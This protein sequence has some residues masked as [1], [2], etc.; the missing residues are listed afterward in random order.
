MRLW[1][2]FWS[3]GFAALLCACGATEKGMRPG[4]SEEPFAPASNAAGGT[5]GGN[6]VMDGMADTGAISSGVSS[7]PAL[8]DGRYV[9]RANELQLEVNPALGGRITRFSLGGANILTGPEV[10]ARGEGTVPNM[11][12]STFWTSP[13]STWDWP[14]ETALDSDPLASSLDGDVLSLMSQAGATTGYGVLKRFALDAT[15]ERVLLEYV[16][17]NHS[18]TQPAAPWE[19]SRVPKEGLVF[20]AAASPATAASTL[21]SQL[22]DGIAWVDVQQAP[23][24]DSKLFQDGSEGWLAYVYRDLVFIKLFDDVAAADQAMGE[25][26]IEVF[27]S[28]NYDY[29]EIEQQGAS[30]LLPV[31]GSSSWRVTWLLRR[32]PGAIAAEL[33]NAQLVAWV[34]QQVAAAR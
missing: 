2:R 22:L 33:G 29:V 30:A 20:F 17:Q 3:C 16:L 14:P 18:G 32:K 11:Y 24:A 6:Q 1:S 10:V 31:G 27:V 19:V 21:A 9:F 5:R 23:G 25:A 34:R 4:G 13:Q 28:G 15:R 7:G 8:V 26:E 12:G